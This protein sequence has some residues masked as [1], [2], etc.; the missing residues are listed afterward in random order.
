LHSKLRNEIQKLVLLQLRHPNVL[1]FK[2]TVEVE[3]KG[4]TIIYLVTE[5]VR[6]LADVLGN[7]AI[8]EEAR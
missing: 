5:S 7:L 3:E 8:T 6:P 4:E 2:F 1:A